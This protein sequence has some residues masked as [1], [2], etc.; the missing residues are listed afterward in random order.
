M[1]HPACGHRLICGCEHGADCCEQCP[2]KTCIFDALDA[3]L[4]S[5]RSYIGM[6]Q[7]LKRRHSAPKRQDRI[8]AL[9]TLRDRCEAAKQHALSTIVQRQ[10]ALRPAVT[11]LP[12]EARPCP[13]GHGWLFRERND[14]HCLVCGH[15][16]PAGRFFDADTTRV[17]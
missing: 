6:H 10:A 5:A 9:E 8:N 3:G 11:R 7:I 1:K 12:D 2:L 15:R 4:T 17:S 13:R 14:Y 16:E